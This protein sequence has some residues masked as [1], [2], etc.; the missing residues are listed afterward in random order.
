MFC[1]KINLRF[2]SP[3]PFAFP[4]AANP[5]SIRLI[6]FIGEKKVYINIQYR[7]C[8]NDLNTRFLCPQKHWE[9]EREWKK[10]I[11][12]CC[13]LTDLIGKS[14]CLF[15]KYRHKNQKLFSRIFVIFFWSFEI[16]FQK[17]IW[18]Y[19]LYVCEGKPRPS[20]SWWRDYAI[21]DDTFEFDNREGMSDSYQNLLNFYFLFK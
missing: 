11:D 14:F 6:T 20:L 12:F 2:L 13:Q 3:F 9:R 7:N 21:I 4:F 10:F 5:H 15:F 8:V 19:V 16:M 18:K 17:V 1:R